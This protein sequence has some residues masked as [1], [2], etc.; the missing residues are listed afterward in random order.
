MTGVAAAAGVSVVGA[1][2]NDALNTATGPNRQCGDKLRVFFN[3]SSDSSNMSSGIGGADADF[4][5]TNKMMELFSKHDDYREERSRNFIRNIDLKNLELG[6]KKR[7]WKTIIQMDVFQAFGAPGHLGV[8]AGLMIA[9]PGL[10]ESFIMLSVDLTAIPSENIFNGDIPENVA[11]SD[12]SLAGIKK[13]AIAHSLTVEDGIDQSTWEYMGSVNMTLLDLFNTVARA[14][15]QG[16]ARG[17]YDNFTNNCIHL[18]NDILSALNFHR[19]RNIPNK[20]NIQ[21]YDL[22]F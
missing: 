3:S 11:G 22:C 20:T 9:Y 17:N 21:K 6:I 16:A 4:I 1:I 15:K 19:D 7:E 12:I 14:M 10:G 18:K 2:A 13:C 8:H 5:C